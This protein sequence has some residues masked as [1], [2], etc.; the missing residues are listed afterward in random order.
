MY[1]YFVNESLYYYN[2]RMHVSR[3][4]LIYTCEDVIHKIIVKY[5]LLAKL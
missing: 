3:C 1:A 4:E 5:I 2:I